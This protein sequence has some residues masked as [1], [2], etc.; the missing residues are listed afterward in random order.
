METM[1]P[2]GALMTFSAEVLA[3]D[4]HVATTTRPDGA[5]TFSLSYQAPDSVMISEI[6]VA[7]SREAT[8]NLAKKLVK[9][10][11]ELDLW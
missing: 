6:H 5:I 11:S 3:P 2:K 4:I 8:R 9:R 1:V 10:L 7:L